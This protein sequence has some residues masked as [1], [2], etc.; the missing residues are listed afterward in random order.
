[1]ANRGADIADPVFAVAL[2]ILGYTRKLAEVITLVL[3]VCRLSGATHMQ[4]FWVFFPCILQVVAVLLYLAAK[5]VVNFLI[6]EDK[7]CR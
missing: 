7:R 3:L 2:M 4:Y 6:R 5:V 1:M